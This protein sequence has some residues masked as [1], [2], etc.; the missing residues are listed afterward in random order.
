MGKFKNETV[1]F[2]AQNLYKQGAMPDFLISGMAP[3]QNISYILKN[4]V[5]LSERIPRE[6]SRRLQY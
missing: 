5:L 1:R 2:L 3:L 6:S 4:M